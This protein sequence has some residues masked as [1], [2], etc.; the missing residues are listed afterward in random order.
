MF[1]TKPISVEAAI[2]GLTKVISDLENV[3]QYQTEQSRTKSEKAALLFRESSEHSLESDRAVK[4]V[5]KF[6]NIFE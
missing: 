2:A 4:I 5:N 6:K 1:A 3:V